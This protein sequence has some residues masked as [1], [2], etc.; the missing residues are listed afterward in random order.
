MLRDPADGRVLAV[1]FTHLRR[2]WRVIDPAVAPDLARLTEAAGL[3]DFNI[4]SQTQD[5]TRWIVIFYGPTQPGAYLLYDRP[6]GTLTPLFDLRPEL[7]PYEL[8]PMRP[9]VIPSRDGLDL[10]GYLTLPARHAGDGRGRCR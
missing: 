10:V 3:L 7:E 8:A 2:D 4:Y 5:G 9:V 6:T 1:S